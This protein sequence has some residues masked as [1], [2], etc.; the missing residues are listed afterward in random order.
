MKLMH[1]ARG[2]VALAVLVAL[3]AGAPAALW[4]VGRLF[5]PTRIPTLD[6]V[7]AVLVRPDDGTLLIG[8]LVVAGWG[9]W[10]TLAAS[11]TGEVIDR[12]RTGGARAHHST[13]FVLWPTRA[14]AAL[15]IG[16]IV[17]AFATSPAAAT[18]P[19]TTAVASELLPRASEPSRPPGDPAGHGRVHVVAPRDTLWDIAAAELGDP[20]RWREI[21]D[22]N[23]GHPQPDG[24]RLG[25]DTLLHVGWTLT[26]PDNPEP[27]TDRVEVHPGDTLSALAGRYLGDPTRYPEL[28]E[29][30]TRAV[31]RTGTC[32]TTPT[33]SA[34]AG[35][36]ASPTPP[37][38]SR[39]NHRCGTRPTAAPRPGTGTGTTTPPPPPAPTSAPP[40]TAPE[41]GLGPDVPPDGAAT[42]SPPTLSPAPTPTPRPTPSAPPTAASP[43][44]LTPPIPTCYRPECRHRPHPSTGPSAPAPLTTAASGSAHTADTDLPGP[45]VLGTAGMLASGLL[46]GLLVL[47]RRQLRWRRHGRRIAL[48][49]A[50]LSR[51]E[52][53]IT[54]A[55]Q[56]AGPLFLDLALRSL[57]AATPGHYPE[58]RAARL[59]PTGV[60][61]VLTEPQPPPPPYLDASHNGD[62]D[63]RDGDG[64]T[65]WR[66]P[67]DAPYP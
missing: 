48:P 11:I 58:L 14:V 15:L 6:D 40:P 18:A 57:T 21:L 46:A 52:A 12:A 31:S 1:L 55:A 5:L 8:L 56:P 62:R 60:D 36:S 7:T 64:G 3:L 9:V 43:P 2:L 38:R 67:A 32:S 39:T 53:G 65:V 23:R 28:Y 51:V 47:R 17:T 30:N 66:V 10:A 59:A 44:V 25:D 49:G 42:P 45:V 20:L 61:L 24:A 54:A 35:S 37:R 26:L 19:A 27:R 16:W 41:P 34:P 13:P 33:S 50:A 4:A 63:G 29:T 22:L